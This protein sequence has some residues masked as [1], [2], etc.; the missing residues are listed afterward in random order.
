[1]PSSYSPGTPVD[2]S[3]CHRT[4]GMLYDLVLLT[5]NRCACSLMCRLMSKPGQCFFAT[6]WHFPLF[7][8]ALLPASLPV[9]FSTSL[10]HSAHS[11]PAAPAAVSESFLLSLP[12]AL[13]CFPS[14]IILYPV[15]HFE[16]LLSSGHQPCPQHQSHLSP[17]LTGLPL[18]PRPPSL[19]PVASPSYLSQF[20][21]PASLDPCV[22][23]PLHCPLPSCILMTTAMF[24][25]YYS[26]PL[27]PPQQ[28][29][30][31]QKP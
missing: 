26:V 18:S 30:L 8:S 31:Y 16:S 12:L 24:P 10:P 17:F 21:S 9:V 11:L 20:F 28:L 1:M 5:T 29:R 23:S 14:P 27:P 4:P 25:N 19:T 7:V 13:L 22:L 2:K 15:Y 3:K 6:S